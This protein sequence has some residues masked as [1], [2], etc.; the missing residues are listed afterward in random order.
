MR[1]FIFALLL[2]GVVVQ[3]T[4][5]IWGAVFNLLT[6]VGTTLLKTTIDSVGKRGVQDVDSNGDGN[7]D[8]AELDAEYGELG[9]REL[10]HF[11]DSNGNHVLDAPE[12]VSLEQ[13]ADSHT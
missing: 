1:S 4:N 12:I 10:M 9:A 8:M 5:A 13:Y 7:L 2:L 11:A 3:P 6:T